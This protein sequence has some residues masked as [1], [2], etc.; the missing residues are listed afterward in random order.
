MLLVDIPRPPPLGT[1]PCDIAQSRVGVTQEQ[2][3]IRRAGSE[4]QYAAILL[5]G[6]RVTASLQ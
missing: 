3:C 2:V 1:R 5:A 6:V 4:V